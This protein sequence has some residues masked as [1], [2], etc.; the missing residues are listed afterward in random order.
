L[1]IESEL[2]GRYFMSQANRFLYEEISRLPL[3]KVG[4]ALSYVRYLKNE[5]E[6][7]L[8]IDML[9]EN[10]LHDL[11]TSSNFV[12]S[13]EVLAKIEELPND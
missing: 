1:E 13:S 2:K 8:F 7:G 10:E 5:A 12:D 3:E 9:E 11:R 6:D 4:K